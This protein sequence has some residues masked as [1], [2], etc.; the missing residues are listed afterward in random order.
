MKSL[1]NGD[2][3]FSGLSQSKEKLYVSKAAQKAF[4]EVNE[5]G[6]EAAAATYSKHFL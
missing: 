2:S 3:D 4:I 1:F 5:K 6:T